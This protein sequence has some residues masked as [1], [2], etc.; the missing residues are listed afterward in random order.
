LISDNADLNCI[1]LPV[2]IFG[3][4]TDY[5]DGW[6]AR[7]MKAVS[8]F[9]KFFDPLADK[10]LTGFAFLGFV[11]LSIV[12]L[13]M[14]LIIIFRDVLTTSMRFFPSSGNVPIETSKPAKF[15]T[16][17]QMIFIGFVLILITLIKCNY[18]LF[19]TES[20]IKLLYSDYIYYSMLAIVILALWTLVDYTK[21]MK[22]LK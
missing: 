5:F 8:K 9:G 16:F 12:P 13:W 1:A 18:E 22:F 6:L 4:V 7:K 20:L 19:E 3:A 10:F 15:K 17:A 11:I 2:F 21:N 14:V